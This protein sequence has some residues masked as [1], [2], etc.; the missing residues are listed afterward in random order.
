VAAVGLALL[1]QWLLIPWFGVDPNTSPFMVFF[2]AVMVA[3]WLGGLGPGLLAV[4][5]SALLSWYFFLSPQNSFEIG[6]AGQGLRVVVFVLEGAIIALLVEAMHSA[7]REA[8]ANALEIRRSERE[9]RARA[10]Q[11]QAVARLGQRALSGAD[12]QTLV[13]DA[14]E[15][16]AG[17]MGVEYSEVLELLS[18]GEEQLLRAGVGWNKGWWAGR[19]WT[20]AATP[21]QAI[22]SSPTSQ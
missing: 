10:R 9:V 16:V 13:Q 18:G 5:L 15:S 7:R 19:R 1:L 22:P 6:S 20:P 3:A 4:G 14:V 2:A 17:V 12:L 21:W 11:Q 8:E